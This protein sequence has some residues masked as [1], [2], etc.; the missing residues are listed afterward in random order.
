MKTSYELK[1]KLS[2]HLG[3]LQIFRYLCYVFTGIYAMNEVM[4]A[5]ALQRPR[6]PS[7]GQL[8]EEVTMI[9]RHVLPIMPEHL[10]ISHVAGK[11]ICVF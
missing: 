11:Y 1:K 2:V 8:D 9:G 5:H 3:A 6:Y 4:H 7:I 10:L